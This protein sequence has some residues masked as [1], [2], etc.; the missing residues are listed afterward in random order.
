MHLQYNNIIIKRKKE[1]IP[2]KAGGVAHKVECLL[3]K[4]ELEFKS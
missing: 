1:K 2:N 3:N 4:C